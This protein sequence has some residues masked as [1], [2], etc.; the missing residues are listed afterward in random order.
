MRI[1]KTKSTKI[2][3]ILSLRLSESLAADLELVAKKESNSTSAVVRRLLA[4]GLARELGR[5]S[6]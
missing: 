3:L 6:A 4:D 2:P 1:S 5:L